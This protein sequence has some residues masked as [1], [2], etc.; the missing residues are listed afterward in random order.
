VDCLDKENTIGLVQSLN[1][2]ANG[3][4]GKLPPEIGL[5]QLDIRS[6]DLSSNTI[7]GTIP[8][9]SSLKNMQYLYLGPNELLRVSHDRSRLTHLYLNDQSHWPRLQ[10]SETFELQGLD[11][12]NNSFEGRSP[13]KPAI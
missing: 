13:A 4:V 9:L 2:S 10:T 7:D 8:D 5:L 3:L 1:L 6:L 11:L 12:H